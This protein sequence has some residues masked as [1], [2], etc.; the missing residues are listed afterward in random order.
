MTFV[1]IPRCSKVGR[2]EGS[3]AKGLSG[4][5]ASLRDGE[6]YA[7]WAGHL[8]GRIPRLFVEYGGGLN[9]SVRLLMEAPLL[10]SSKLKDL[11]HKSGL[12]GMEVGGR[13]S[14]TARP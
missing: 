2:G 13:F 6:I 5:V 11:H 1:A 9:I 10:P 8:R 14:Q 3:V 7:C 12:A 4:A